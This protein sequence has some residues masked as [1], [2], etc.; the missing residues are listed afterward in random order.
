MA[1]HLGRR[2]HSVGAGMSANTAILRALAEKINAEQSANGKAGST[3]AQSQRSGE[4]GER[5]NSAVVDSGEPKARPASVDSSQAESCEQSALN[6]DGQATEAQRA[7]EFREEMLRIAELNAQNVGLLKEAEQE[8][9]QWR[10][11]AATAAAECDRLKAASSPEAIRAK[12]T[13]RVLWEIKDE[14]ARSRQMGN[15]DPDELLLNGIIDAL[16]EKQA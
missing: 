3:P 6:A 1:N 14:V 9:D 13:G 2:F 4:T 10:D 11:N 12:L 5:F 15:G 7:D 16:T 8:R